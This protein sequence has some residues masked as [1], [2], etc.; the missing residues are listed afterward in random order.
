MMVT[1]FALGAN[2]GTYIGENCR[3]GWAYEMWILKAHLGSQLIHA[4]VE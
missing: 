3:T 2:K 1:A 4:V